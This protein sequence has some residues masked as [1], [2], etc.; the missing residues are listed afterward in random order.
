MAEPLKP[1]FSEL[2]STGLV[3]Y[4]GYVREDILKELTGPRWVKNVLEMISNDPII[5]AAFFAIDKLTRQVTWELQP[6]SEDNA[7]LEIADF[8]RGA[9]FD[10]MSQPWRETVGEFH[11]YLPWGWSWHEIVY[12]RRNGENRDPSKNSKFN[13][14]RIGWR[15]W[16]IRAQESL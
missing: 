15:K 16:P 5:C 2:G 8:V 14:G 4:S 11:S 13:D 9:L 7:D 1:N 3:Q 12:K 10:D 6:G